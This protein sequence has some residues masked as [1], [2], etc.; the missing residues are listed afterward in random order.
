MIELFDENGRIIPDTKP[1]GIQPTLD[2]MRREHY[3]PECSLP[4]PILEIEATPYPR[5]SFDDE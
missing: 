5:F 3:F 4:E 1:E 2:K